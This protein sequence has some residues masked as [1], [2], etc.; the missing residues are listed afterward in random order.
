MKNPILLLTAV[1]VLIISCFLSQKTNAQTQNFNYQAVVRDAM[2]DVIENQSVSIKIDILQGSS[3][4]S[5]VYSE[6]HFV[7]TNPFG[8]VNLEIGAGGVLG[9]S[10]TTIN[11]GADIYFIQTELDETGGTSY[12]LMG[13]AQLL[14]VPYAMFAQSSADSSL[15]EK[16]IN[17]IYYNIG[18]VGIG[19]S[20]ANG[21]LLVKSDTTV[22]PN[23]DIFSVLNANGDTVFAVYQ[24]GV[25]IWVSEDTSCAKANGNRGGFAVGGFCPSKASGNEYFRVS[26]DSVRVYIK[27]TSTAPASGHRGGFAVGGFAPSKAQPDYFFNIEHNDFPE[28][29]NSKARI[30]WYPHNQRQSFPSQLPEFPNQMQMMILLMSLHL[31]QL[32]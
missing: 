21:K 7:T 8:L 23:D 22:A 14:T 28:I 20:N 30:L 26:P 17:D 5:S 27:E 29:I 11:W 10:F 9:G 15:W 19:A 32:L 3:S 18:N 13:V 4:G 16:N 12:Q 6:E 25:R 31:Y 1:A 2:G 24:E